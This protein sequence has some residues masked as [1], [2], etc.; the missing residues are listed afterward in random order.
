MCMNENKKGIKTH[1]QILAAIKEDIYNKVLQ[2]KTKSLI[3]TFNVQYIACTCSRSHSLKCAWNLQI[4]YNS[5][6]TCATICS[7]NE[8]CATKFLNYNVHEY[9]Y[10]TTHV[11]GGIEK[12]RI[13][14]HMYMYMYMYLNQ[15]VL[16]SSYF[17]S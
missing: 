12:S 5:K 6:I 16:Q 9:M 10:S 17:V 14:V 7:T 15:V 4:F 11:H 3:Y 2:K 1:T 13:K 8:I